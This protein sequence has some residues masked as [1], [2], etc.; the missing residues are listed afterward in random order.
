MKKIYFLFVGLILYFSSQGQISQIIDASMY[1]GSIETYAKN[2]SCVLVG[3]NGGIFKTTNAGQSWSNA[4]QNFD[5]YSVSCR[6]IVSIGN[7]FYAM[8]N[9]SSTQNVYK[10]SD[11]GVNWTALTFLSWGP[12]SLGNISNTL[13]VLG[14]DMSGGHLYA[15]TDGNSWTQKAQV[16]NGNWQGGNCELYSFNQNKLYIQMGDSLYYTTDGNNIDT[17]TYTGLGVTS[18]SHDN[19]IDGDASGNLY[20]ATN[21]IL[22]KYDFTGKIWNDIST[23]KIQAGF[24]IIDFSVTDNA[25]F[26]VAMNSSIGIKLYKS[27]NQGSTFS[28]LTT[29]LTFPMVQRII[30]VATNSFIG[31]GLDGQILFTSDGGTNWTSNA[32]QFIATYA[33]NLTKSGNSLMFS[34]E[35]KGIILSSNQGLSW[36]SGNAGIPN[37]GG[38]AYFVNEIVQAKD[39][40]FSFCRTDPYS[41]QVSLYKSSNNGALWV[42]CPIPAPYNTGGDYSFAGKC[43]S[44]IFVSYYD[45]TS[46]NYAFIVSFNN[47]STW[48]KPNSQNNAKRIY[49]EGIPSC[50]FACYSPS[51]TWDDFSNIYKTTDFGANFT[52]IS[53]GLFNSSFEIKR[54]YLDENNKGKA[55]MDVDVANNLAVFVVVDRTQGNNIN[56]L[57]QYNIL[58]NTWSEIITSGLPANYQAN[59]IKNV[60]NNTWL[61]ATN[62]GLYK[63]TNAGL[64]WTI[65]HNASEWQKGILVNSIKMIGNTAFLGTIGN[66]IWKVE[67]PFGVSALSDDNVLQIF[68]NPTADILNVSIPDFKGIT[69]HI[70]LYNSDG[71]IVM[72]KII[73]NNQFQLNLSGLPSGNY[74][75][76]FN[77]N[78]H[79][80]KKEIIRK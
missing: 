55:M 80:Y 1:G 66:G 57:Y 34:R 23:G 70:S 68:P 74:F 69:A 25:V 13:Y 54:H 40:L 28:E 75:L 43:D 44:A 2:S 11:N 61:L 19:D 27:I 38:I 29:N 78:D 41:N 12:Q 71:K 3:T 67:N 35:P 46:S 51:N 30:E 18:F 52:D 4:T 15:S 76:V 17:V 24:Q 7:D 49:L 62:A 22:Y 47:G 79:T 45:S 5:P 53:A 14:F 21:G 31:N 36:N 8:P 26:I 59:S 6:T 16:W 65:T 33:G 60:G 72:N 64:N 37:F 56:R 48:T 20:F 32:N 42:S 10:S 73:H 58:N 63:S 9:N 50:L 39:T 77:S